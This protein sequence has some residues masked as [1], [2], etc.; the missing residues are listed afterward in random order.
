VKRAFI[1]C[2]LFL[3]ADAEPCCGASVKTIHS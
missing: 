2:G 3:D 1:C